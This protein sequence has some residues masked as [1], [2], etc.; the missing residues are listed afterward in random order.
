[1]GFFDMFH[2][3]L[4]GLSTAPSQ[5]WLTQKLL[6]TR[7]PGLATI[8]LTKQSKKKKGKIMS[9]PCATFS[10]KLRYHFFTMGT[11]VALRSPVPTSYDQRTTDL[12]LMSRHQLESLYGFVIFQTSPNYRQEGVHLYFLPIIVLQLNCMQYFSSFFFVSILPGFLEVMFRFSQNKI[13]LKCN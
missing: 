4:A 5:F 10:A 6:C 8:G 7:I 11:I 9:K 3:K 12:Q 13:K 2:N 1:M